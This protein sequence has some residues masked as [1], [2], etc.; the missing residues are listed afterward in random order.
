MIP[1]PGAKNRGFGQFDDARLL[2]AF[3]EKSLSCSVNMPGERLGNSGMQSANFSIAVISLI[4][5]LPCRCAA[6]FHFCGA[7]LLSRRRSSGVVLPFGKASSFRIAG[8]LAAPRASRAP[9]WNFCTCDVNCLAHSP[10]VSSA[11]CEVSDT[12]SDV[13]SHQSLSPPILSVAASANSL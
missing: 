1:N 8:L 6:P 9:H 12:A 5:R 11:I 3:I 13:S 2:I 10:S 4:S 7:G